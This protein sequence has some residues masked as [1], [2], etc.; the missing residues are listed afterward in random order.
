MDLVLPGST[1]P[2]IGFG[3]VFEFCIYIYVLSIAVADVNSGSH[4]L[5]I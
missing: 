3:S 5:N 2:T 1:G 4:P